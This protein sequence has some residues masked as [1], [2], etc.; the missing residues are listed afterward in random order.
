[1][2]GLSK[3]AQTMTPSCWATKRWVFTYTVRRN[4]GNSGSAL[5]AAPRVFLWKGARMNE[6]ITVMREIRNFFLLTAENGDFTVSNGHMSLVNSYTVGQYVLVETTFGKQTIH[7]I[8]E[9]ESEGTYVLSPSL[10]D[11]TFTG[12]LY[13]LSVPEDFVALCKEIHLFNE[14]NDASVIIHENVNGVYAHTK[15]SGKKGAPICWVEVFE[16]RLRPFKKHFL[17]MKNGFM[18]G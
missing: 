12:T 7:V 2:A 11:G 17:D 10:P 16:R 8:S 4:I 14:K 6:M 18:N 13:G 3:V 5:R 1:M 15:G 9:A